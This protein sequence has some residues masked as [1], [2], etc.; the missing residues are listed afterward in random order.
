LAH[1]DYAPLPGCRVHIEIRLTACFA[2]PSLR[3]IFRLGKSGC[4]GDKQPFFTASDLWSSRRWKRVN[5]VIVARGWHRI[6]CLF[7]SRPG[8]GLVP[9]HRRA[10]VVAAATSTPELATSLIARAR[11][12]HDVGLGNILGSNIFNVFFIAAVAAMI[13]PDAV[14]RPEILPSLA[15]GIVTTLLILPGRSDPSRPLAGFY[16]AACLCCVHHH[17]DAADYRLRT[18][19]PLP[20]GMGNFV[21]F[22]MPRQISVR[23][24]PSMSRWRR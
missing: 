4:A 10:V 5:R 19:A 13:Q 6:A 3:E 15:F 16:P 21:R 20:L 23:C 9:I 14:R 11:G 17:H 24:H 18:A 2:A 12:H 22:Q 7:Q 1:T 8:L